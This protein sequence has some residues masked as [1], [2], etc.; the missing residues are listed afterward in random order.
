MEDGKVTVGLVDGR[1]KKQRARIKQMESTTEDNGR[2]TRR[3]SD[4]GW[5]VRLSWKLKMEIVED[6]EMVAHLRE[7]VFNAVAFE[8]RQKAGGLWSLSSNPTFT[9]ALDETICNISKFVLSTRPEIFKDKKVLVVGIGNTACDISLNL[10][11]HASK[12][13]QGYR[14][15]D[16]C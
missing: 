16:A 8:R 4:D 3:G 2:R 10:R 12:I 7:E 1:V 5:L 14:G 6:G 9:P 11:T 13:Y 15:E